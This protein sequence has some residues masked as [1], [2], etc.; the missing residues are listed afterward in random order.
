M[1]CP[2]GSTRSL[3]LGGVADTGSRARD[4][5]GPIGQSLQN[6]KPPGDPRRMLRSICQEQA[7]KVA[8]FVR[9]RTAVDIDGLSRPT[10]IRLLLPSLA[11]VCEFIGPN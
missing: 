6:A 9:N 3:S 11:C 5:F 8:V 1:T 4:Q 2:G 10:L 7:C